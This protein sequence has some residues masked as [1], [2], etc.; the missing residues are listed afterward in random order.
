MST[1]PPPGWSEHYE[2]EECD[3]A[4]CEWC[5]SDRD[6]VALLCSVCGHP[7]EPWQPY[8]RKLSGATGEL[9]WTQ[10]HTNSADCKPTRKPENECSN[11][12]MDC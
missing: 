10:R 2:T 5:K 3:P 4:T 1:V 8:I 12:K 9:V 6:E 7:V 11:S